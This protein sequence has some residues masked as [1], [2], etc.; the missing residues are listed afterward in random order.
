MIL[1]LTL[2][3]FSV[4][5]AFVMTAKTLY[6]T[7]AQVLIENLE[8]PYERIQQNDPG[9]RSEITDADISS[10]IAV[11][12]SS[13]LA[14][15]VITTLNLHERREFNPL[16][17]GV[18]TLSKVMVRLG[19]KQDPTLMT[20]DQRAMR[21]FDEMLTIYR[22]PDSKVIA[23]AYEANDP[24]TAAE[25]ANTLAEIYVTSTREAQ[26]EPT[27]RARDWL[28]EQIESLRQKV[29]ESE[30][31][32][33]SFRA[34]AGLLKGRETTLSNEA[35]SELNSQIIQAAAQR[36]EAQA[37]AN[38]I[39]HALAADGNVDSSS[40]VLS[41]QLIQRLREQQVALRRQASELSV[42]YLPNHPKMIA[43][44]SEVRDLDR[45]LKSEALKIVK[46]LEEQSRIAQTREATLRASL[47]AAK[48]TASESNLDDVR[49]RELERE[50]AANREILE[51]LLNRY[52]DAN[53]RSSLDA[54]PGMARIIQRAMVPSTPSFPRIGPTILLAVLGG[55][56]MGLGL[57][58]LLEV[59]AA[60]STIA[61]MEARQPE[62]T[63]APVAANPE[64]A[65][66]MGPPPEPPAVFTAPVSSPAPV[67]PF[68]QA[69]AP[70]E[71]LP[72]LCEL[73]H[74][75]DTETAIFRA[76][77]VVSNPNGQYSSALRQLAS[78][79]TSARQTLGVRTLSVGAISA[80]PLESATTAM[81]LARALAQ[82][83]IRVIVVDAARPG[84]Q[85]DPI[86]GISAGP[87]VAEMLL[88]NSKF[89]EVITTDGAS[90]VHILRAGY[91]I[92]MASQ[93]FST[94]RMDA[95]LNTLEGSYDAVIMNL[96]NID[97]QSHDLA[98]LSQA[99]V[100][101]ATPLH[102]ATISQYAAEWRQAGLR[103]V[104]Y[105]RIAGDGSAKGISGGRRA[106][107]SA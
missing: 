34:K 56:L 95:I 32:A 83:A 35:L 18:G 107:V 47:N 58:F 50:A 96:G 6:T 46:G 24:K 74:V 64:P 3:A 17:G 106:P 11:L 1:A 63:R 69:S 19:F 78:W 7:E 42:T 100:L 80:A 59:M 93:Y 61:P 51:A 77:E 16:S 102:A 43:V 37:R 94:N 97:G 36:G 75:A 33:E 2:I 90:A 15:R 13:D 49:L 65:M 79:A 82:Q 41:S 89:A 73:P 60:A 104:Q 54:Q 81:A 52:T 28:S 71:I 30:R 66:N 25:I 85:L 68:P 39:R 55:F 62:P 91:G 103:A 53:A 9:T 14:E 48:A 67:M 38:S 20:G 5:T 88:G 105:V 84:Q 44:Q 45:Q 76:F 70:R 99:G 40:D 27:S 23:I 8:T 72:A 22:I 101:L 31:A 12:T 4:S 92:D 98:R 10:Q 21:R 86:A 57:A 87:G 26:S 29:V